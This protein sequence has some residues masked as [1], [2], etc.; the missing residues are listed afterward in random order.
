[1]TL[2][3]W[4]IVEPTAIVAHAQHQALIFHAQLNPGLSRAGVA[5]EIVD[6]LFED[7]KDL[8][9]QVR[10]E[11]DAVARPERHHLKAHA[12]RNQQVAG[13]FAHALAQIVQPVSSR[14]DGPHDIAHGV[15]QLARDAADTRQRF[16]AHKSLGSTEA[17]HLAQDGDLRQAGAHIVVEVGSNAHADALERQ[18]S[19]GAVAMRRTQRLLPGPEPPAPESTSAARVAAEW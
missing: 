1:M 9:T 2:A 14:A 12:A 13:H 18:Q 19:L 16:L 11:L 10:A 6:A 5:G 17:H 15:D 4:A 3:A 7:Q 8:A